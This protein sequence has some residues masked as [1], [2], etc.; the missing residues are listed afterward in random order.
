MPVT[1][2][3]DGILTAT[4]SIVHNGDTRGTIT[5]F[6]R[7]KIIQPDGRILKIPVLSGNNIR[8]ALRRIGESLTRDALQY[9]GRINLA[10]AHVLEGGGA[11]AKT[12]GHALEGERLHYLRSLLP[13][14][15]VF[16]GAAGARIHDGCAQNSHGRPLYH[17][18]AHILPEHARRHPLIKVFDATQIELYATQDNRNHHDYT[19][20]LHPDGVTV[21]TAPAPLEDDADLDFTTAGAIQ[22]PV[23]EDDDQPDSTLLAYRVETLPAGTQLAVSFKI[24]NASPLDADYYETVINTF[25]SEGQVGGRRRVGH[26]HLTGELTRTVLAG[27]DDHADWRTHLVAHADETIDAINTLL[28]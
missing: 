19:Q 26:G 14:F 28:T 1:I 27:T 13:H 22:V 3:W 20:L 9:D 18:T 25:L 10:A 15:S 21:A 7:E 24:T 5:S 12:S 6:R 23:G 11:L 4:S 16:G 2:R 17:E 8:G